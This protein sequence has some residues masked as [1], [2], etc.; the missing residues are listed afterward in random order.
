VIA[1]KNPDAPTPAG[2]GLGSVERASFPARLVERFRGRRFVRVDPPEVL[3]REGAELLLIGAAE[4]AADELG[5][6]LDAERERREAADVFRRL[7]L[8]PQELPT[9]PLEQCE[10]R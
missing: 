3:D 6:E 2:V 10:W 7:R 1:V 4:D 9:E 8:R 5:I